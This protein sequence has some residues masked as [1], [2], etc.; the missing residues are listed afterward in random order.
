M[1]RSPLV[2]IC[3][4]DPVKG[5]DHSYDCVPWIL[6]LKF[7]RKRGINVPCELS[8]RLRISLCNITELY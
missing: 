5:P 7:L 6:G 2:N 4:G 1:V 3:F 8:H